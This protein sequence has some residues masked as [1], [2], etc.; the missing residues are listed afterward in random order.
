MHTFKD[1]KKLKTV[2][3]ALAET[4]TY[5]GKPNGEKI[6]GKLFPQSYTVFEEKIN[7]IKKQKEKNCQLPIIS[8]EEFSSMEKSSKCDDDIFQ[9]DVFEATRFL[10]NTGSILYFDGANEGLQ[11]IVFINPSWVCKLMSAFITE[12]AVHTF[13]KNG[14]LEQDKFTLIL[15]EE[16]G[17]QNLDLIKICISLLSQF[18]IAC[19]IDDH[20]V[21]IP[22]KLPSYDPKHALSINLN[23]VGKR[24]KMIKMMKLNLSLSMNC[25]TMMKIIKNI[26]TIME[27][28]LIC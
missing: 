10:M 1:I 9:G 20:R 22:P 5:D 12:D 13:V 28:Q 18:Q 4:M 14:I 16:L 7:E 25:P 19:K 3:Y 24:K 21:L 15:K 11:D 23:F 8:L 17:I 26:L 6:M 27:S 2:I